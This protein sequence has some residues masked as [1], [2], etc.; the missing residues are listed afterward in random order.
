MKDCEK[1]QEMISAMLDKE[2][3]ENET[4][5]LMAHLETCPDCRAMYEAFADVSAAMAEG[6][7]VPE[8]LHSGIMNSVNKAAKSSKKRGMLIKLR[9]YAA[10]AACL[11]VI[12]AAL[13]TVRGSDLM[14]ADAEAPAMM[15]DAKVETVVSAAE[16]APADGGFNYTATNTADAAADDK[17]AVRSEPMSKPEIEL[18]TKE[19][20][21]EAPAE[22]ETDAVTEEAAEEVPLVLDAEESVAYTIVKDEVYEE[23]LNKVDT[24]IWI[25]SLIRG[26]YTYAGTVEPED[27]SFRIEVTRESGDIYT[28][29]FRYGDERELLGSKTENDE[30]AVTVETLA[31]FI[32]LADSETEEVQ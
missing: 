11:V 27:I 6:I 3:S 30:N 21:I 19:E 5:Q 31:D 22:A 12:A 24:R 15:K 8:S 7:A 16:S 20:S 2:L 28:L 13:L 1:F 9:P 14:G 23:K 32:E 17:V 10:T 25:N 29:H 26:N 18:E 4:A